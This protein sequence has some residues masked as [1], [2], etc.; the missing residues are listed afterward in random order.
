MY[1]RIDDVKICDLKQACCGICQL[2][3]F[4]TSSDKLP[5]FHSALPID[6]VI[7]IISSSFLKVSSPITPITPQR[8]PPPCNSGMNPNP[9]VML[10]AICIQ[11]IETHEGVAYENQNVDG[12]MKFTEV[13]EVFCQII[14]H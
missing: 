14:G 11:P 8:L 3:F 7:I 5:P 2:L 10:S 9:Y 4:Y 1:G 6:Q 12:R 13:D